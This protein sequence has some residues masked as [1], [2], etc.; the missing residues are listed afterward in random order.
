MPVGI[1]ALALGLFAVFAPGKLKG[2]KLRGE[3]DTPETPAPGAD[4][5]DLD[6]HRKSG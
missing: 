5:V 2:A 4:V 6:Q 3:L 1:L